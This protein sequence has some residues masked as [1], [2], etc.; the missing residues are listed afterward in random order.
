MSSKTVRV[1]HSV[2]Q[3]QEQY[4]NGNKQALED[5]VRAWKGIEELP[6]EDPKSFF[7]LGG[8]HGEPF[9]YR[10]AV[11][12]LSETD[13]YQYWGEIGRAHV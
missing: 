7:Q 1:R 12:S 13:T 3:L 4:D 5:L 6:P 11:D 2:R 10:P 9:I 8:Y